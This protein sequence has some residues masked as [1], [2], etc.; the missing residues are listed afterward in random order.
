MS[1]RLELELLTVEGLKELAKQ[2]G[3]ESRGTKSVLLGRLTNHFE[4]V[5]WPTNIVPPEDGAST[6]AGVI[7]QDRNRMEPFETRIE[8]AGMARPSNNASSDT[9]GVTT[10]QRRTPSPADIQH[11]VDAVVRVL[12]ERQDNRQRSER[13]SL[14]R[15]G[16]A[17]NTE[18]R[19]API[20]NWNQIKFTSRL[21]PTFSAKEHENVVTWLNRI[22]SVAR[23]HAVAEDVLVIAAVNQL[24][25]TALEWYNRQPIESVATWHNFSFQLRKYFERKET[26]TMTMARINTRVWRQYAEKFSEYAEDK[27]RLMQF[28]TLTEKEQVDLLADGIKD[29]W[30]RKLAL[31]SWAVTVPD[32]LEYMRR[33]SEDRVQNNRPNLP[34][35]GIRKPGVTEMSE[36]RACFVCN[37]PGHQAKDCRKKNVT[38][39]KCGKQGHYSTDCLGRTRESRTTLNLVT[40]TE[41]MV[42]TRVTMDRESD[43]PSINKITASGMRKSC[44]L[45]R[46]LGCE[47]M[48]FNAL[49]DTGSPVNLVKKSVFEKFG[50]NLKLLK[51]KENVK[52]TGVND[53]TI[54]VYGKVYDQISLREIGDEFFDVKLLVVDDRTMTYEL[55][56]GREFFNDNNLKLCY[57][58]GEFSFERAENNIRNLERVLPIN[59]IE[60]NNYL[61][62]VRGNL[63]D[64]LSLEYINKLLSLLQEVEQ[65][66]VEKVKDNYQV[67]VHL[68][69]H[70]FFR[71]APRRMSVMERKQLDEITDDL[72]KR[73]IIKYSISPYC[74]RVVLVTKPS[75]KKRMCVDLRP[76]NERIYPQKFPFPIPEDQ[77]D[78]LYNKKWFTKL[79]L[80]DSFHQI[81][82]HSDDTKYFSFA[83]PSG[84]FEFVKLP[85][86]YSESPAEFQKRILFAFRDLIQQD[87]VLVYIDDLLIATESIEENLDII[88]EVRY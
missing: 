14:E 30:M 81:D 55:I 74:A 48:N 51:V 12:E 71:Y 47:T 11:I 52:L 59:A 36:R 63:D 35:R 77:L 44:V 43:E 58:N 29:T 84:Q 49:I 53:S 6:S 75:G 37:K 45:V 19:Q 15:D 2:Q 39:Y 38:C 88:K 87:K 25:G 27:L 1:V 3:I 9:E 34:A 26:Y 66:E 46:S 68:K 60:E 67:R 16:F 20:N 8:D 32:F 62:I 7:V 4:S 13:R 61:D 70:S 23:L 18:T 83:T 40:E 21:I 22:S 80:K 82:I 65:T 24:A 73:K 54:K 56:L 69:D 10:G 76:L 5:G 17:R 64:N 79:D 41:P 72:L 57:Q 86:G 50:Q 33:V 28:L 85:F 78:K 31:N 42:Q